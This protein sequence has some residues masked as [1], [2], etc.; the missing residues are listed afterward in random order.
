MS[1]IPTEFCTRRINTPSFTM[2]KLSFREFAVVTVLIHPL[3]CLL[4]IRSLEKGITRRVFRSS[5]SSPLPRSERGGA[6]WQGR[7]AA[8][9]RPRPGA[10]T[11]RNLDRGSCSAL[12][13]D[14]FSARC[15]LHDGR[16]GEP[17]FETCQDEEILGHRYFRYRQPAS[18]P[19][20][21]AQSE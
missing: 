7:A 6:I 17:A 12:S 19:G 16:A 13:F 18:Q 11:M 4:F 3:L 21:R 20:L 14:F 1:K 9:G 5:V 8:R 10:L 2:I 15:N